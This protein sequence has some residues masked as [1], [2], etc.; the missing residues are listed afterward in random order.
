VGY[1]YLSDWQEEKHQTFYLSGFP[2]TDKQS[3]Q[4]FRFNLYKKHTTSSQEAFHTISPAQNRDMTR[5]FMTAQLLR[6]W[7]CAGG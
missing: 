1:S 5:E 6:R 7:H 2:E 4:V 3:T